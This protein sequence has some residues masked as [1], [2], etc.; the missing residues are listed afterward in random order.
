[1]AP[2]SRFVRLCFLVAGVA[3]AYA[4]FSGSCS[5]GSDGALTLTTPGITVLDQRDPAGNNVFHFTSI[6]IGKDVVVKLSANM[7]GGPVVWLA[8]GPVR[9]DGTIDLD[10]AAGG[11]FPSGAGAGGY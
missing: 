6:Y 8:Q 7:L 10:G 3:S 4:Q 9:I 1:M 2:G 5:N 11:R